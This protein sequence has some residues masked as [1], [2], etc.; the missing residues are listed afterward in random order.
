[1]PN[2]RLLY[3]SHADIVKV[4]YLSL[5]LVVRKTTGDPKGPVNEILGKQYVALKHE[6]D[7]KYA[8]VIGYAPHHVKKSPLSRVVLQAV[9]DRIGCEFAQGVEDCTARLAVAESVLFCT[10][11]DTCHQIGREESSGGI[12]PMLRGLEERIIHRICITCIILH[13]DQRDIGVSSVESRNGKESR[14]EWVVDEGT[15]GAIKVLTTSSL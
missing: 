2:C 12:G 10:A 11:N 9:G 13:P 3:G 1:M 14:Q 6:H 7:I 8:R 5:P 4:L 15:Q